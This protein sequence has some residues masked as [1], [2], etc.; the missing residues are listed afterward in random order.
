MNLDPGPELCGEG[1]NVGQTHHT[2]VVARHL[3]L[4]GHLEGCAVWSRRASSRQQ[5]TLP[6]AGWMQKKGGSALP[7]WMRTSGEQ[8]FPRQNCRKFV[9][10]RI[11]LYHNWQDTETL[12]FS[13]DR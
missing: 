11:Q 13:R 5:R 12:E 9:E 8:I 10:C 6:C 1:V 7:G 2:V 3:E 4:P